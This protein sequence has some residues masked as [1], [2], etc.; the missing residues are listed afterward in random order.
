MKLTYEQ[1]EDMVATVQSGGWAN[2]IALIQDHINGYTRQLIES[3]DKEDE[4]LKG[5]IQS[6]EQDVLMLKDKIQKMWDTENS[7]HK[8]ALAS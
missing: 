8:K 1:I 4:R 3:S 2:I 6:L 5:K 7:K